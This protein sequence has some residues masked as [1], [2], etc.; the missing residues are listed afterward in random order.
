MRGYRQHPRQSRI[1]YNRIDMLAKV[2]ATGEIIDVVYNDGFGYTKEEVKQLI[3]REK[4]SYVTD[5]ELEILNLLA[6]AH[7]KFAS[8][9][10]KHPTAMQEWIFYIHGLESLIEHR[11]CVRLCDDIF[12]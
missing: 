3:D 11:I 2:K 5:E 12:K 4:K 7:N 9:A 8:L 1:T 6:D 10:D